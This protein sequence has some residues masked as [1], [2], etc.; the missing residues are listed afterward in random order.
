MSNLIAKRWLPKKIC[1]HE[2]IYLRNSDEHFA[3]DRTKGER[4]TVTEDRTGKPKYSVTV[5]K[6]RTMGIHH[7]F[8]VCEGRFGTAPSL[9]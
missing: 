4:L 6:Q 2:N 5:S 8:E 7:L 9:R 1:L 3:S